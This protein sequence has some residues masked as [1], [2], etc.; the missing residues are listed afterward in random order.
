MQV[1]RRNVILIQG[2]IKRLPDGTQA[3]TTEYN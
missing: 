2:V 1:I 3:K